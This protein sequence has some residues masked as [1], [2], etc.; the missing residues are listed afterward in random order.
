MNPLV[1]LTLIGGAHNDALMTAFL[2]IGLGLAV[3]RHPVWALFFVSLATAIKAPAAIGLAF[4]AWN[5]APPNASLKQRIRPFAIGGVV[6]AAVLGRDHLDGG[7]WLGLDEKSLEQWHGAIVGRA[8]DRCGHGDHQYPARPRCARH[9]P[10]LGAVGDAIPRRG[11]R[12]GLHAVAAVAVPRTWLGSLAGP[13]AV[14]L[15]DPRTGRPTVVSRVGARDSRGELPGS[16]ALLAACCSRS[17]DRS[18]DYRVDANSWR[19]SCTRTHCSS[20]WRSPSSGECWCCRWAAGPSG[21]GPKANRHWPRFRVGDSVVDDNAGEP[22]REPT[23]KKSLSP[24]A[25]T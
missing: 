7:L 5:W 6:A 10:G 25:A 20:P 14:A 15:R 11:D 23:P 22:T 3:K 2:V 18:S 13:R 21:R 19:D 8:R 9:R 16:R 17:W 12:G 1:L 4:V 24:E